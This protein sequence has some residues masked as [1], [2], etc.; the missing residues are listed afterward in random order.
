MVFHCPQQ[1][2]YPYK[3]H[4]TKLKAIIV[5]GIIFSS[6]LVNFISHKLLTPHPFDSTVFVKQ[7]SVTHLAIAGFLVGFG[8]E[9][10]NGCTSGH[11]LCGMP[12]F[13]LRSFIAVL[14]FLSTGI[15]T[16]TY[17]LK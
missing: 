3:G 8:T 2:F 12:R 11:G 15:V 17:S 4:A 6:A 9:L 1:Y 7:S 5:L 10:A 13:S 16:A 14:T